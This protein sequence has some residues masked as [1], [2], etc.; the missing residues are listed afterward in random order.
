MHPFASVN[1]REAGPEDA[2]TLFALRAAITPTDTGELS[3]WT[4]AMEEWLEIGGRAWLIGRDGRKP[5]GYGLIDEVPGL[6]GVYSLEG[7][8]LSSARRHGLGGRLLDHIRAAAVTAGVRQLSARVDRL[9]DEAAAFLLH[10]GFFVEHEECLLELSNFSDL[11]PIPADPP[12]ELV[13]YPLERAI[14]EFLRL[15]EE[16]FRGLPWSQPYSADE[17]AATLADPADLLFIE[18]GGTAAGFAWHEAFFNGR[19][20][21]E[22]LGVAPAYQRQGYGR[23]LLLAALHNLRQRA[24]I[25]EIGT[26]RQNT[27]A[28]NLYKGLGFSE[29]D[30]WYYL[31]CD[32]DGLKA[33]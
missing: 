23:R 20:R 22:P 13:T 12:G 8:V 11:T 16:S 7:G 27:T 29:V 26:W 4:A 3:N 10:R 31:A 15:Y 25:L 24:F 17:V 19:G 2:A 30:H 32:L 1:I 14:A 6:S 9:E 18:V 33:N 28:L 5:L 21:V